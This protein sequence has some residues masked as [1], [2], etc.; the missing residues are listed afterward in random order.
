MLT[1][2]HEKYCLS[3]KFDMDIIIFAVLHSRGLNLQS[4]LIKI[5]R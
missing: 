2:S 5:N 4:G 3:L 1:F